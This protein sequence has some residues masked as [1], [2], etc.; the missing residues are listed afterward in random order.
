MTRA[1]HARV[2]V[3]LAI[4]IA[5]LAMMTVWLYLQN[6]ALINDH[7]MALSRV[8]DTTTALDL[9][10]IVPEIQSLR[11]ELAYV[12]GDQQR[13]ILQQRLSNLQIAHVELSN[14]AVCDQVR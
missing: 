11:L 1:S 6:R 12:Q 4:S 9:A 2:E 13:R 7:R 5:L 14:T 10:L 3:W 8:C